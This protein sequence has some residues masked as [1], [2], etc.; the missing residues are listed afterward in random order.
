MVPRW[1]GT[2]RG[3]GV[4]TDPLNWPP[5][6]PPLGAS[7]VGVGVGGCYLPQRSWE[8]INQ[9]CSEES[10]SGTRLGWV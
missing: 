10:L 9:Q 6:T 1:L 3:L 8:V 5:E 2:Q 4:V 7:L